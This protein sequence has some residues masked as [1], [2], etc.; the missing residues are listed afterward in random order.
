MIR[1]FPI[2]F[3]NLLLAAVTAACLLILLGM[4][5]TAHAQSAQQTAAII[6]ATVSAGQTQV[7][8]LPLA[9]ATTAEFVLAAD[10]PVSVT[11][12]DPNGNVIDP[13]TPETNAQVFYETAEPGAD[14]VA[15]QWL[16][17]YGLMGVADGTWQVRAVAAEETEIIMTVEVES[18]LTLGV[19]PDEGMYQPGQTI[20]LEA[21]VT[22]AGGLQMGFATSGTVQLPDGHKFSLKFHDD[23]VDGDK[24]AGNDIQ[25][26]RFEAPNIHGDLEVLVQAT[27]GDIV[28]YS[29]NLVTVVAQT[30]TIH[31][32]KG[33]TASDTDG[34]GYFDELALD[35]NIDVSEEGDYDI[36]GD[37][38][39]ASGTKVAD[40][41][42]S[43]L[44][45]SGEPL[46]S[47]AHTVT[48]R[49][50]GAAIREA[51]LDGPYMLAY[52]DVQH[53]SADFDFPMTVG[54]ARDV[55]TTTAFTADQFGRDKAQALTAKEQVNDANGD[56]LYDK[57]IITV[58]A[59]TLAPGS[60]QWVGILVDE[61]G[62]EVAQAS[63]RSRPNNSKQATLTFTGGQ[64]RVAGV[65][66]P[67]Q[68]ASI[69][70]TRPG[71]PGVTYSFANVYTTSPYLVKQFGFLRK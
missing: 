12:V 70:V 25:T 1:H 29:H 55:Y 39:N 27:K 2:A 14:D 59:T 44:F 15:P 69:L 33:E 10:H 37:L 41:D 13:S 26:A 7:M 5:V 47:G 67:Y 20:T 23:G 22:E 34:D 21:A 71:K 57:L 9:A 35:V 46:V 62:R 50:N 60:Y 51:G 42:Y 24:D 16:Y 31:G 28:R 56:G 17:Y 52:L 8:T 64:L 53:H 19:Y 43:T 3:L 58:T 6:T 63:A 61:K 45:T 36:V 49:Y 40:G 32:V 48:L 66:G 30:A 68:L 11:L 18:A 4:P 65:Y 38:Y 54:Y